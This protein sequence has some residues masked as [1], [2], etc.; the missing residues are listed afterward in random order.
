MEDK[1]LKYLLDQYRNARI[2]LDEQE[3]LNDWYHKLNF[4]D[5]GLSDAQIDKEL[6][7]S[8]FHT[9][10]RV[11]GRIRFLRR[12]SGY[13]AA[14]VV[15]FVLSISLW[16]FNS[17][18]Q[19]Q[20]AVEQPQKESIQPGGN[21]A[22]LTL[23]DGS[24]ISLT[25]LPD[26]EIAEQAGIKITKTSDG[27][28]VYEVL[29][30]EASTTE[31]VRF[32]TIQTPRG[33]Q[34]QV[35]LPDG[36]KVWL[37]AAST[38]RYPLYFSG[39]E[40][41]VELE[42]EGY[43]EIAHNKEIPFRVVNSTQEIEVLGTR[44]NV[45]AYSD[46]KS[47]I[48]TLLEGAVKI[49]SATGGSEIIKPGQQVQLY[50]NGKMELSEVDTDLAVAWKEGKFI[51]RNEELQIVM[52]K[53]ARWYDVEIEYEKAGPQKTVWGN[54]SKFDDVLQVLELIEL[55]KVAQFKIEGRRIIV[56]E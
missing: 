18:P 32:N 15:L 42:G 50:S 53:L 22:F 8:D 37:N 44:F 21:K 34:Y 11:S 2:S 10:L 3:E 36:S 29:A 14:A 28:L 40:R 49:S 26:G 20:I 48:T 24:K 27:Q 56:M 45:N 6:L 51:F 25:D 38:L 35:M 33:G 9:R 5:Q 12:I 31:P 47:V 39:K 46:E 1:R 13:A 16:F 19:Q 43:F 17:K 30:S 7:Y 55:S 52:R 4:S 54:V 41:R 23:A